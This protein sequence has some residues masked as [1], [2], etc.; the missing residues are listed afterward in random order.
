MSIGSKLIRVSLFSLGLLLVLVIT[1]WLGFRAMDASS[2]EAEAFERQSMWLQTLFRGM[3]ET[4]L[5]EGTHDSISI[6]TDAVKGFDESHQRILSGADESLRNE[7]R[8]R[9]EGR[10]S[11]IKSSLPPFLL[12]NG[13]SQRDTALMVEYGRLLAEGDA[14]MQAVHSLS[15][16]SRERADK[17]ASRTKL[18]VGSL[19]LFIIVSVGWLHMGLFRQVALPVRKLKTLMVEISEKEK[20]VARF[21]D[22]SAL[23]ISERLNEKERKLAGKISD[24]RDLTNSFDAM[25][26]ALNDHTVERQRVQGQ[27]ERLATTDEL[28]QSYNRTK[29]QDVIGTEIERAGRYKH[30]LSIIIFDLDHFKQVNDRFGHLAGDSVLKATADI[31]RSNIRDSDF[32][33]RLGGEEFLVLAPETNLDDAYLLAERLRRVIA[34]NDFDQIESITASFGVAE[35]ADGET[36][37]AFILKADRAM[38]M[39]KNTRNRVERSA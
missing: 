23:L 25:I 3:N 10:W 7:I 30:P 27:L 14:L 9:T 6:I 28:T 13:V 16:E 38:Y 24:I 11:S 33:F 21:K 20:D 37:D 36:K 5:T 26:K 8:Q 2:R 39:A 18:V 31:A 1:G 19:A 35:Y 34:E 32:L 4:I 12:D 22:E 15:K 17:T 29:F